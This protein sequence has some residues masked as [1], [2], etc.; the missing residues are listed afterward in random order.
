[1]SPLSGG[2]KGGRAS[3]GG[4]LAQGE[5][6]A[7]APLNIHRNITMSSSSRL[8][9]ALVLFFITCHTGVFARAVDTLGF[10]SQ[11]PKPGA[12]SPGSLRTD[13]LARWRRG[14]AETHRER[15]AELSAP[16]MENSR[17]APEDH[18]TLLQLRVRPFTPG[19]SRG[20]VFPGKSLFSFVRRVYHCCQEGLSCRSVKGIQGRL[21]GGETK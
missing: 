15:C 20:P 18:E 14:M 9:I 3:S 6:A 13:A 2:Y 12:G 10:L 16:W 4:E 17:R 7:A 8:W 11:S 5:A 21:R 1:M 19:A